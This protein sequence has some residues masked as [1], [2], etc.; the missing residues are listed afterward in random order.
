MAIPIHHRRRETVASFVSRMAAAYHVDAAT[1][2]AD[3]ESSFLAVVSGT[4][5]GI[6]ALAA[7]GCPIPEDVVAWSPSKEGVGG[8]MRLFRGHTFPS[9]ILQPPKMRGCPECLRQDLE[10]QGTDHAAMA[11]R[12]H[13]LVPHVTLCLEHNTPLVTLWRES[14]PV[15]RFDSAPHLASLIPAIT[16]GNLTL[17]PRAPTGFDTWLDAR[18]EGHGD[19]NWL[20][21]HPLHAACNYCLMLGTSLLRHITSAPSA[22]T[23]EDKWFVYDLGFRV[24]Q[25]GEAA[26]RDA[27]QGLQNLSG[28]PHDG[29]KKI[30]PKMYDRLAYDTIE[31]PDYDEFRRILRSH[32]METW[33]LGIGDELLGEPIV[34][35]RLH[36]VRSAAKATGID[37]RRLRKIL[38]AEGIIPEE[39]LPDA[40]QV[41][42]AKLADTVLK[43]ATTL[44]TAK[45]FAEGI[46]A[47]RSQFNL[48]VAG[49]VLEPRLP[50]VGDA[51][52]K[53]IWDPADGVRFLDS[54]FVGAS[55]LRQAQHGWEHI[56]KSAARLMVGPEV[57]IKAIQ[58]R[59]I[60]RIGNHA[61]FD[62]YAALYVYH[63]E[64]CSVLSPEPSSNQSIE[65][66][67]KTVGIGQP[68]RMKRLVINGHTPATELV[69]PK[70]K[71][72]QLFITRNDA[73]AFH[74][75]FY[76]PRTMA[77]AH[78]KSWQ[79]MTATL[80]AAGV[81]VFS[82]DGEDYGT[83]YLREDVDRTLL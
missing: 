44:I 30:F 40:W 17:E 25:Q 50:S 4:S 56:S 63:D 68:I 13:W 72:R 61:D 21:Q 76:T 37:Q 12:G 52:T 53:A 19:G 69:H 42:D 80:R 71:T 45:D 70:L 26:I 83:L 43:A 35:R 49:G 75:R 36:S 59:R 32:M 62:G 78:G 64:V 28:G 51:G 29:P 10:G 2:S 33:P 47:S 6:E 34:E 31:N 58:D 79:S 15:P 18:L 8:T 38:A 24:A 74:Q 73:D 1:F 46:N 67:S 7:F 55:P 39:G 60:V 22:V 20:E 77:Q 9:K 65:L 41:F 27:L 57:I 66:F 48:L 23:D 5:S 3:R 11:M 14:K 54:V 16:A 81:K 82:P